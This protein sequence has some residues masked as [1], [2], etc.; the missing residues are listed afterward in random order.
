MSQPGAPNGTKG[1]KYG[2]FFALGLILLVVAA[3][4]IRPWEHSTGSKESAE[5]LNPPPSAEISKLPII[6][7]PITAPPP[8]SGPA[9]VPNAPGPAR[10]KGKA[11][12]PERGKRV[13]PPFR[14]MTLAGKV[15]SWEDWN[16]SFSDTVTRTYSAIFDS[17]RL[18]T[19]AGARLVFAAS[20]RSEDFVRVKRVFCVVDSVKPLVKYT[21]PGESVDFGI[22]VGFAAGVSFTGELQ[23]RGRTFTLDYVATGDGRFT[24]EG[25]IARNQFVVVLTSPPGYTY[26][27]RTGIEC[28]SGEEGSE[29]T[30]TYFTHP[31]RVEFRRM[32]RFQ[33]L[34]AGSDDTLFV[35]TANPGAISDL[36][37]EAPR[38]WISAVFVPVHDRSESE[39]LLK[40]EIPRLHLNVSAPRP[41]DKSFVILNDSVALVEKNVLDPEFKRT[42]QLKLKGLQLNRIGLPRVTN[43][44]RGEPAVEE[45][46][47]LFIHFNRLA[48][49]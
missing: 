27:L 30:R 46:K 18:D 14:P 28:F 10:V 39:D 17:A 38:S 20:G 16:S 11:S 1:K 2:F 6:E 9:P 35:V 12:T 26:I 5:K 33:S 3:L 7:T 44:V 13:M 40:E 36:L 47:L 34:L 29:G 37:K 42:A 49:R 25:S 32:I 19:A 24:D 48:P 15:D 45:L 4:L 22:G 41:L 43:L 23:P 21:F 31:A 8:A